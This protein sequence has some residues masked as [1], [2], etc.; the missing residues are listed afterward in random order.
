MKEVHKHT[1]FPCTVAGCD[2]TKERGYMREKDLKKHISNK[3]PGAV[4][5]VAQSQQVRGSL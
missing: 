4:D 2:R 5:H 3:H 1:P